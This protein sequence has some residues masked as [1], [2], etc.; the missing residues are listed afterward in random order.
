MPPIPAACA[1]EQADVTRLEDELRALQ[2]ELT[3]ADPPLSPSQKASLGQQIN[4]ANRRLGAAKEALDDC[5]AIHAPPQPVDPRLSV[6]DIEVVSSVQRRGN[7]VRLPRSRSAMVRVFVGSGM[8]NGYDVGFGPDRWPG[9]RGRLRVVDADNGAELFQSATPLNPSGAMVAQPAFASDRNNAGHSLNFRVPGTSLLSESI[10]FEAAVFVQGHE[11]DG[12]GWVAEGT[13]MLEIPARRPPQLIEPVLIA[14]TVSGDGVPP[15]MTTFMDA[16]QGAIDRFPMPEFTI[17]AP[18]SI[19]TNRDLSTKD[20]WAGLLYDLHHWAG[21]TSQNAG[22]IAGLVPF[23]SSHAL[24]GIGIQ[25]QF[26]ANKP[27][28]VSNPSA[29]TFAHEMGHSF[30]IY[31]ANC[32]GAEQHVDA[33]LP[34]GGRNDQP[35]ANVR[36][37]EVIPAGVAEI[38]GYCGGTKWPSVATY[39]ILY[40]NMPI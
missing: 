12:G 19:A 11:A 34:V 35:G 10:R 13:V 38:M 4:A 22:I 17:A 21:P 31:H 14:D 18:L 32:T 20:G 1:V 5:I 8:S 3:E 16:L 33:R 36:T 24:G 27:K 9:V 29:L 6:L 23:S 37:G 40:D 28:F 26:F 39:D 30:G 7:L 25:R 2:Q 15:S